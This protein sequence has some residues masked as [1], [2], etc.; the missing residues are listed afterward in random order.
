MSNRIAVVSLTVCMF[1]GSSVRADECSEAL[2]AESCTAQSAIPTAQAKKLHPEK[3]SATHAEIRVSNK[4]PHI[5][6]HAPVVTP[7]GD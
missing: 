2:M 7:P 3:R 5:A 1:L 4:A 6:K